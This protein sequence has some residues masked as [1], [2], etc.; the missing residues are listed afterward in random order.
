MYTID[1]AILSNKIL[2]KN[3]VSENKK[4]NHKVEFCGMFAKIGEKMAKENKKSVDL[5][6]EIREK[7]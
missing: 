5:V 3:F 6:R 4:H 7:Q 1:K 2:L